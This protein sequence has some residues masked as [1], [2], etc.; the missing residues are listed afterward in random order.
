VQN[1]VKTTSR[2]SKLLRLKRV[3]AFCRRFVHNCRQPSAN[4][5][6]SVLTTQE[7]DNGLTCCVKL[8]QQTCFQ[9]ELRDLTHQHEVSSHSSLKA[10]HPFTD[11]EGILRVGGRLQKSTLP[12]QSTHQVILPANHHFTK[13]VVSSEHY[14]LLHAGPQLLIASL[15][16]RHWIPKLRNMA[17]TTAGYGSQP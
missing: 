15:R 6:T 9:H 3:V 14:R 1:H 11:Q 2:F 17:H 4:R 5:L 12:F 16:E 7:L 13:L 10:L 8:T